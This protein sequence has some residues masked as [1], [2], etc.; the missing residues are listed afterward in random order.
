MCLAPRAGEGCLAPKWA[1]AVGQGLGV[2]GLGL[3][4]ESRGPAGGRAGQDG[5]SLGCKHM[6]HGLWACR[7]GDQAVLGLPPLR[8]VL[9]PGAPPRP[10]ADPVVPTCGGDGQ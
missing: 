5:A 7:A 9:E 2:S 10:R 1:L 4:G 8:L 6:S 3:W